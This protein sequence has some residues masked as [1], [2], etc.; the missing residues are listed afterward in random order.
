[1]VAAIADERDARPV[2]RPVRVRVRTPR[3]NER[4]LALVDRGRGRRPR[5]AVSIDLA[6]LHE[7]DDAPVWSRLYSEDEPSAAACKTL[8][9]VLSRLAAKRMVVGHTVQ[10]HGI[11]SACDEQVFRIDVGMSEYYGQE[12]VSALEITSGKT[13]ILSGNK[14]APRAAAAE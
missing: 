4:R 8:S 2:W 9:Q 5:H 3:L 1:M 10:A 12:G 14:A 13:R 6:F 7:Q 11:S